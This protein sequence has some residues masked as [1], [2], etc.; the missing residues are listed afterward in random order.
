MTVGTPASASSSV[1]VPEAASAARARRKADHFSSRLDNDPRRRR[2]IA[3]RLLH[4][5][6]KVRDR[7]QHD[8]DGADALLHRGHRRAE[9][10]DVTPDLAAAAPRQ[11]EDHG[12]VGIA[13]R[14]LQW[15]GTQHRDLLGEGMADIGTWRAA[16]AA[17]RVRLERQHREHVIDIAPHRGG[18]ARPPCPY[19]RGHIVDDR[20]RRRRRT[21][22]PRHPMGE[23]GTVDDD[24]RIGARRDDRPGGQAEMAKDRRQPARDRGKS[25]DGEVGDRDQAREALRRHGVSA[26][27]G[28]GDGPAGLGGDR[29]HQRRS[30]PVAGLLPG[31]NEN[32][33]RIVVG[34]I[35]R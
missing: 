28:K 2:P 4:L 6:D 1:T 12:R 32:I 13:P 24:Q 29:R 14:G 30:Q 17:V 16:E 19:G 5:V 27:A 22:P 15:T 35:L 21:H 33:E 34:P 9:N 25:I 20:D 8:L 31:D 3:A 26:D 18:P 7:R 23:I 10:R 11:D